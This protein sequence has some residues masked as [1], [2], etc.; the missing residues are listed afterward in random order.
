MRINHSIGKWSDNRYFRYSMYLFLLYCF[1]PTVRSL[2]L[3]TVQIPI[4]LFSYVLLL[5]SIINRGDINRAINCFLYTLIIIVFNYLFFYLQ[6]CDVGS[7]ALSTTI[8]TNFSLFISCF[9]LFIL[10]SGELEYIRNKERL[11][12]FIF[13]LIVITSITTII[14]TFQYE[15]ACRQLAGNNNAEL[16]NLY[17]RLNIGGYRFIYFLVTICPLMMKRV[18]EKKRVVDILT[19]I[20]MVVCI[21]RSEY[22]IAILITIAVILICIFIKKN[23]LIGIVV[24]SIAIAIILFFYN[25]IIT[26]LIDFY[27]GLY[28]VRTRLEMM[29]VYKNTGSATGDLLI[30]QELMTKSW[31]SFVSNPVC[32]SFFRSGKHI[33]GHSEILDFLGHAGIIGVVSLFIVLKGI[34]R[35][36]YNAFLTVD[37]YYYVMVILVLVISLLNTFYA[38]EL[39]FAIFV[40]PI[41]TST[42][43]TQGCATK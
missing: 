30:R 25:D 10:Y 13:L 38:P 14:G 1:I 2:P 9:S 43:I 33:G 23:Q 34:R 17:E 7:Q 18:F 3:M 26:W 15:G 41:L 39:F 22:T 24:V 8:G 27:S 35:R 19:L 12:N 36:M 21:L 20:L 11:L 40:M 42:E 31:T 6:D 4:V 37:K 16:N 29:L 28:T 32:G 5:I